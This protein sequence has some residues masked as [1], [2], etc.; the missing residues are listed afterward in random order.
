M[1]GGGAVEE[2][3]DG[4]VIVYFLPFLLFFSFLNFPNCMRLLTTIEKARA[5]ALP[6]SPEA[7]RMVFI[8]HPYVLTVQILS[9]G[10]AQ[11]VFL[12]P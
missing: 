6:S 3:R 8:A 7:D 12:L 5:E 9:A 2:G 11:L 1:S 10:S 4:Q